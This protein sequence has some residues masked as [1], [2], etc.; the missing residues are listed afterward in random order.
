MALAEHC[1]GAARFISTN[2][3]FRRVLG[4]GRA[5]V[6]GHRLDEVLG[7]DDARRLASLI[8][9]CLESGKPRR[10]ERVL[11]SGPDPR[12]WDVVARPVDRGGEPIRVMLSME[13]LA[14]HL[15]RRKQELFD[16]LA[17]ISSGRL[18]VYDLVQSRTRYI[19][20]DLA[21]LL[22]LPTTGASITEVQARV[23][24]D[25]L[26]VLARHIQ[27]MSVLTDDE[28]VQATLRVRGLDGD[29][30]LIQSRGRVFTRAADGSV[31]R[32]I[33]VASDVTLNA[34]QARAV[35]DVEEVLAGA[36]GRERGRIGRELHDSTVQHLVAV[37]LSLATL[38]RRKAFGPGDQEILRDIRNSLAAAHREIRTFAFMLHPPR[39][40]ARDLVERLQKFADGFGRRASLRITIGVE[41][42]PYPL[43][44]GVEVA[45]FRIFQE[46]LMNVHRHAGAQNVA[47]VLRYGMEDVILEVEDDG[48]G[49][50][51]GLSILPDQ[52]TGVGIASMRARIAQLGGQLEL[53]QGRV[54]LHLRA[55]APLVASRS[56]VDP[57][58]SRPAPVD[59]LERPTNLE[60][61]RFSPRT[62][63]C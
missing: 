1:A 35:A 60:A 45:L 20:R 40:D 22:G 56:W 37:D 12:Q 61:K 36:E 17:P 47:A 31:R 2:S 58:E 38:E 3:A 41:G 28:V 13:P 54:G 26:S 50:A 44:P 53:R 16:Q 52:E 7:I 23:H 63:L 6:D 51:Q 27:E 4:L 42:A 11:R 34:I 9:R 29:W 8:D 5:A 55:Q 10:G 39:Q 14:Q 43:S 15:S 46:A 32:V 62:R 19:H 30:R 33:G 57:D 18:Y 21:L 59:P 25:D 24:P 49:L 48:V